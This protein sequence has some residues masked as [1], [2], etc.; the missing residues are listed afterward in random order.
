MKLKIKKVAGLTRSTVEI[1]SDEPVAEVFKA[2][3]KYENPLK[4]FDL[5]GTTTINN[6]GGLITDC[7][8]DT[9]R[10]H[11]TYLSYEWGDTKDLKYGD[12][13]EVM[14]VELIKKLF[15]NDCLE[16]DSYPFET[17]GVR[18]DLSHFSKEYEISLIDDDGDIH[19]EEYVFPPEVVRKVRKK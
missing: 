11:E 12:R 15:G 16:D 4:E 14:S 7:V 10:T 18:S 2:L 6:R 8:G 3:S 1:E 17:T 13:I 5:S 9:S 19:T